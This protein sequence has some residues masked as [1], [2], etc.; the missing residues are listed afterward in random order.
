M[1]FS[2]SEDELVGNFKVPEGQRGFDGG[3]GVYGFDSETLVKLGVVR[4]GVGGNGEWVVGN[5]ACATVAIEAG[6]E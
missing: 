2:G 1:Y 6:G 4:A 5:F 3:K